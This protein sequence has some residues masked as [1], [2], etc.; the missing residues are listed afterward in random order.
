MHWLYTQRLPDSRSRKEWYEIIGKDER[1]DTLAQIR[2]YAFADRFMALEFQRAINNHV[3]G[4]L[5]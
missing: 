3:V 2:A 1:N 4:D 5:S